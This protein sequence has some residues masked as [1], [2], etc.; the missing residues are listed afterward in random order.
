MFPMM[1]GRTVTGEDSG[2]AAGVQA[3]RGGAM[4]M[5]EAAWASRIAVDGVG[6]G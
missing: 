3:V 1:Y 4:A 5:A 2:T 6:R